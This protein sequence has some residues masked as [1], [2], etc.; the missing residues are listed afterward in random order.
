MSDF[1]H[2]L[3]PDFDT[4]LHYALRCIKEQYGDNVSV[5]AKARSVLKFGR[6]EAVGTG[7]A[8][9]MTLGSGE[10]DETYVSANSITHFASSNAGDTQSIVIQ[11]YTVD[12]NG[13]FTEVTQTVTLAG[14]TKTALTTPL[15]RVVR[16]YNDGTTD[17]AGD[18]YVAQDVTFTAGVPQTASAIH[19]VIK[20][21]AGA[22]QSDKCST[23]L[24][25]N[26]YWIVTN[27]FA[28]VLEK[29]AATA[30]VELQIRL[31]GKVFRHKLTI[32]CS[33]NYEGI[34]FFK[35]YCLIPP[36]SDVR[37]RATADG[38]NTDISGGIEGYLAIVDSNIDWLGDIP[39]TW[40]DE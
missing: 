2:K 19:L 31:K 24:A 30:D 17:L 39:A 29:T 12:G 27:I 34:H 20:G 21:T 26:E 32:S 40:T 5:A 8:T 11:G 25:K 22:N 15:A 37:L 7:G 1:P 33:S 9:L 23:T 38:A 36:N 13:D 16:A 6:N 10:T 3:G 28:D 18:V 35:P 14:Q 4:D